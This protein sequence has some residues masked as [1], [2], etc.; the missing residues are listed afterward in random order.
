MTP[1]FSC[2]SQ[3]ASLFLQFA[4][5]CEDEVG[6]P[7]TGT[8]TTAGFSLC[9][10]HIALLLSN[11]VLNDAQSGSQFKTR[12]VSHPSTLESQQGSHVNQLP[13]AGDKQTTI[14]DHV[15]GMRTI[16]LSNQL[17]E[18]RIL[19]AADHDGVCA[20]KM[21]SKMLNTTAVTELS[22]NLNIS[23]TEGL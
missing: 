20:A 16:S 7:N 13:M 14:M 9:S 11:V 6:A 21:L 2:E 23:P 8:P 19:A 3:L 18:V 17:A 15:F 5:V 10:F 1:V 22:L 12:T 4:I